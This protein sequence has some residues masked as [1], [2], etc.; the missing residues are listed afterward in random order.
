MRLNAL[1]G[2]GKRAD[3]PVTAS[4][5]RPA[6][7]RRSRTAA[8]RSEKRFNAFIATFPID[9]PQYLVLVVIDEPNPE[10]PGMAAT[11]RSECRSH[12]RQRDQPDRADA[13]GDAPFDEVDLPF[14]RQLLTARARVPVPRV[15]FRCVPMDAACPC[16]SGAGRPAFTAFRAHDAGIPGT[17]PGPTNEARRTRSRHP[18]ARPGAAS[19]VI[20]GV[21]ADS[22]QVV[23]ERSSR[24]CREPGSRVRLHSAGGREGRLDHPARR[25]RSDPAGTRRAGPAGRR[26]ATPLRPARRPLLCAPAAPRLW[27]SPAPTARRPWP[28][29]CARSGN[30]TDLDAASIGTIGVAV[31]DEIRYGNMTT[32]DPETLHR[33]LRDLRA[34]G[35]EHV[36]LEASSHGLVQRRLD[37][38]TV[39]AARLQ[40]TCPATIST[41]TA[42][43]RPIWP[44]SCACSITVLEPGAAAVV[45]MDD[46]YGEAFAAAARIAGLDLLTVGRTAAQ[47]VSSRSN[48]TA[49]PR[50]SRLTTEPARA[51]FASRW[52]EPSRF[53][54]PSSPPPGGSVPEMSCPC[55]K[56]WTLFRTCGGQRG[57]SN[58]STMPRPG[59][60]S[61][62]T[63]PTPRPRWIVPWRPARPYVDG[64]LVVVFGAARDRDRGKRPEMGA[65]VERLADVGIVTDDNPRSEDPAD[66]RAPSLRPAPSSI[67]IGDRADAIRHGIGLLGD[68]DVLL[69]A[70]KATRPA[71]PS[72]HGPALF[73]PRCDPGRAADRARLGVGPVDRDEIVAALVSD[74]GGDLDGDLPAE[75]NVG[76][77][78]TAGRSSR[79]SCS[80]P[81]RDRFDGHDFV[82]DALRKGAAAA[83][84]SRGP[85]TGARRRCR[86][87]HRRRRRARRAAGARSLRAP[88][89][90]GEN[91]RRHG[92]VGKTSTKEALRTVLGA[93]GSVHASVASFNNHWGVPLTL[94]RLPSG[95]DFGVFEIGMNHAGEITP[96]TQLVPAARRHRHDG[97]RR[98]PR[99]FRRGRG[100]ARPKRR[101]SRTG[102]R[103]HGGDQPGQRMVRPAPRPCAAHGAMVVGFGSHPDSEARLI[104]FALHD[105]CSTVTADILGDL[106]DV[107][108]GA[109]GRHLVDT[110]S[111]SWR[112]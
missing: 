109:P 58:W 19:L 101:S 104:K 63:T 1:K 99:A 59:R 77:R 62:S 88:T 67:E 34:E 79:A 8:I 32:P 18:H 49:S 105:T 46:R 56:R 93:S 3:I 100:I 7:R 110:R 83:V 43:W 70:G 42:R 89:H 29:S 4:A 41:T 36:A 96:L 45:N 91:R 85:P 57:A 111:P 17:A 12:R 106:L 90:P 98:P 10:Q 50:S 51:A 6:P 55:R 78:S 61:S 30:P 13:G 20:T 16:R 94:S 107:Q 60:R 33:T 102:T 44:P 48:A 66:I 11:G 26:P 53:P 15:T 112:L 74:H 71:R 2:S 24:H 80:S 103:R 92:S 68:G 97:R 65:A 47:Y 38:L 82:A 5:A 86:S 69:V 37:G 14:A 108:I 73:R 76:Y 31:R 28:P 21:T 54:T 81:L 39:A 95:V 75:I 40:P 25:Q 35:V 64:K 84:V 72:G 87:V 22:R 27:R 52:W 23:G 9:D